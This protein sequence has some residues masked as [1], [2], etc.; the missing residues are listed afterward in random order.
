[1]PTS[2]EYLEQHHDR[3]V[4]ELT[5]F[6]RIGSVST[7]PDSKQDVNDCA[8][9]LQQHL[10]SIG[11]PSIE[12]IATDGHPIVYAEDLRAGSDRPT[13]LLYGHYDVQ[14]VDPIDLWTSP[15][16]EPV[17]KDGK[18]YARGATDDKGQVFA[19]V[20]ALQAL[21][22]EDAQLPINI[23]LLIEGEEEI[24]SPNLSPFV[25]ENADKLACDSV[26]VSDTAMFA[27]GE[28]SIV[29]GLR[30]LAYVQ[31][32]VQGPNR[33]LHSGSYG[34]P[35]QNPLNALSAIIASMKDKDGR[36][37]IDGF[38]DGVE[39]LTEDEIQELVDLGYSEERLLND[40]GTGNQGGEAGYS[41]VEKL[42]TRPTLDV[43]G[44][45]GGF[46]GSGAKTVLPAKAMAKISSRLV[47]HQKHGHIVE[48][49]R[50]HV[51]KNTPAGVTATVTDL[52]GADPV[53][54]D[55]SA[56]SIQTAA[57]ALEEVFGEKCK[58][59][60]EGGS[61]PVVELFSSALGV[62]TVL[63][64]FGLSNENAHSP[65]EHFDL[66]NFKKGAQAAALFYKKMASVNNG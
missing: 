6:L 58:F 12:V 25:R 11:L 60:R 17:I 2:E 20:K 33:D 63:M 66:D 10:Q 40:V 13:I 39:V 49:I 31:I 23:K 8:T 15:P 19:H 4:G 26:I 64:G 59:Q 38:Y 44:L 7:D 21:Y 14:P 48:C 62:P 35:V 29:Y 65:D 50:R 53:L 42:W 1:M 24:G 36:V 54:V 45:L 5:E 32:D 51:E 56:A 37:L 22:Q 28:P 41:I 30:G 47:P 34:G 61:I 57:E 52:H 27:P 16:F 3:S 9:W 55:K 18:I 43:N 46:T